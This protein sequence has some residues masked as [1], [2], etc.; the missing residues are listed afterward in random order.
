MQQVLWQEKQGFIL[1]F[2]K[3]L[4]KMFSLIIFLLTHIMPRLFGAEPLQKP[5]NFLSV[6]SLVSWSSKFS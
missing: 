2:S 4:D 6:E 1:D 3:L 5:R